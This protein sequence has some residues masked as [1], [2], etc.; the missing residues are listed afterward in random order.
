MN[1]QCKTL[2]PSKLN[3]IPLTFHKTNNTEVKLMIAF[4]NSI[5]DNVMDYLW[6]GIAHLFVV[7]KLGI[8]LDARL[9]KIRDFNLFNGENII[10]RS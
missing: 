8:I 3:Y 9:A 2:I 6:V 10:D 7:K 4:N 5:Y 1:G